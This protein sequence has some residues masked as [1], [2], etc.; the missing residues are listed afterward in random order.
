MQLIDYKKCYKAT[1]D[2]TN[3][4]VKYAKLQETGI[5]WCHIKDTRH[6]LLG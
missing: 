4:R 2:S 6:P 3:A 1:G 5:P